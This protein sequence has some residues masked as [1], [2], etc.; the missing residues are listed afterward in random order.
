[1]LYMR[2]VSWL[3]N[4]KFSRFKSTESD[5]AFRCEKKMTGFTKG[6]IYKPFAY[7]VN[8]FC[9]FNF[10]IFDNKNRVM[11]M[12]KDLIKKQAFQ[13]IAKSGTVKNEY[14]EEQD[15]MI[16]EM[17]REHEYQKWFPGHLYNSKKGAEMLAN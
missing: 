16:R 11:Y 8:D 15:D 2:K 6:K 5:I 17:D 1:M 4:L 13:V 3:K 14:L 7:S 12:R 10:A 9:Y